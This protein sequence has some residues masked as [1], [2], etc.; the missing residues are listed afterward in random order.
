VKGED[1]SEDG[2][3]LNAMREMLS[4]RGKWGRGCA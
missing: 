2:E 4:G 1:V 3:S